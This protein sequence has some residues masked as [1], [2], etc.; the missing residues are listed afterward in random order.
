MS[1][2]KPHKNPDHCRGCIF[3]G[4]LNREMVP[5][6]MGCL[7]MYYTGKRRP[8][9]AEACTVRDTD[10]KKLAEY[11]KKAER[12]FN[13]SLYYKGPL[14]LLLALV[15]AF[16]ALVPVPAEA[17]APGQYTQEET[18]LDAE[19]IAKVLWTECRGVDSTTEQAA[20]AWC[21]LNRV[22]S[23][24]YPDT[25]AKVA[26]QRHQFAWRA[27]APVTDELLALAEDV[28]L[29]WE[30]EKLGLGECGR[31][32]PQDYIYFAGRGGR[33]HFRNAYK[34]GEYWDWSLPSPYED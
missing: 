17:V 4:R 24:K 11:K 10:K 32:L 21:I 2:K 29:R 34:G 27:S 13:P 6:L 14:C 20:V 30:L 12:D 7:Y 23:E 28:L 33:N 26:R 22:D 5:P 25:V 16:A 18:R 8:N 19:I 1:T 31:V 3:F 15:L 9:P